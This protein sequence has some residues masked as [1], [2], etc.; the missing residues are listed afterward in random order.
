MQVPKRRNFLFSALAIFATGITSTWIFR[1][2]LVNKLLF[3][4]APNQDLAITDAPTDTSTCVLTSKQVEGPFYFPSKERSNVIENK[5]GEFLNLKLQVVQYPDCSPVSGAVVEIW[6]AD[7]EGNYS[8]Y[9]EEISKD[10][11]E[12][13]MLFGK[14]GEKMPSGEYHVPPINTDTFLRGLQRTDENGWVTFE[15]IVPC[16]YPN[17]VPHIHFKV[18]MND[19][20]WINSQFYFDKEFCDELFS[21][22]EPYTKMGVCPIEYQKDGVLFDVKGEQKGLYL[23]PKR[24]EKM[25]L[26]ADAIIGVQTA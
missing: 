24:N 11:W 18:F 17:R 19:N 6:Q 8:G 10:V 12:M 16:W 7:A 5:T 13:F 1:R 4:F 2:Q 20:E 15:T 26:A 23:S 22:K 25:V 14:R 3:N 21:T 9:P